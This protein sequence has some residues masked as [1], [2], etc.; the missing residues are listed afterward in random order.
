M[1]TRAGRRLEILFDMGRLLASK[2]D[3]PDLLKTVLELAAEVVD[4]ETGSLL[5]LDESTQEL[6][7]DVALGLGDQLASVR[8]KVGQ[9]IAGTV[10]KS[11]LSEIINDVR[12]DPRWS[13]K[14]DEQTGFITRSILAA[15]IL[16]KGRLI[17][18]V[19]AINKHDGAFDAEDQGAFEA[20]ASQAAV[21]IENARL[22]ASLREERFKLETVFSQM[23]DGAVLTD[24]TG[25][26]LL[27]NSASAR[28]LGSAP[29][30]AASAFMGLE[31][32]PPIAELLASQ[33]S[34]TAFVATRREPTL[35]VLAGRVTRAPLTAGEG[36]LFVFR[37]D[38]EAR[39][40]ELLKRT[41][42]S[43]V[44]HKLKTPVSIV[45]GYSDLLL[46]GLDPARTDP[47]RYK[48]VSAINDQAKKVGVLLEKL[49]RYVAVE[50]P[51][52]A[53]ARSDEKVDELIAE[54]IAA[55][56]ERI[57]ERGAKIEAPAS[58]LTAHVDRL[59]I[60]EALKSLL[61]NAVKFDAGPAPSVTVAATALAEGG[62][63]LSVADRGPGIP[64]EAR[65]AVFS[66]FHQVEKDFTG[67]QDGMGLGLA[68]VRRV[69]ELHGG[70]ATL[71]STLG[72]GTTVT[73]RL[74]ARSPA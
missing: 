38:T 16:L 57:R 33:K 60:V 63:E 55:S 65:D 20:F 45:I 18:V 41:F 42:L 58:S 17:G 59:L 69:A 26:V 46:A 52:A 35:F 13:P 56:A 31:T 27:A 67:Q 74:P 61:D 29:L 5:L 68:Y 1:D 71:Q 30:D 34:D 47:S 32:V 39:R 48:S 40:Q 70:T 2:L 44:S 53:V 23:Q 19:E 72:K 10:A 9:G 14:M 50:D 21:A 12:A 62:V 37:D 6:Y 11:R 8:L 36:R 43:L 73:L 66:R 22:F 24:A 51:E 49:L 64:P 7:F 54:S 4:A 28:L 25:K 3:L 15:P